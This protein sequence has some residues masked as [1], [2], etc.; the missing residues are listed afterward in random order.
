MSKDT[1][2]FEWSTKVCSNPCIDSAIFYQ[3]SV[4]QL[5]MSTPFIQ[6]LFAHWGCTQQNFSI[7]K[8]KNHN[9]HKSPQAI[10]AMEQAQNTDLM[11]AYILLVSTWHRMILA[12]RIRS[13]RFLPRISGAW[14]IILCPPPPPGHKIPHQIGMS[15]L[16]HCSSSC[17]PAPWPAPFAV[18]PSPT[19]AGVTSPVTTQNTRKR[20]TCHGPTG[21]LAI[22]GGS[23]GC[24]Y[25]TI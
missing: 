3:E 12:P 4:R 5:I 13:P 14:Y 21:K 16:L 1:T 23:N 20:S 6:D 2:V 11:Y 18:T 7:I 22:G 19:A 8:L 25:H 15:P 17:L 10:S 24:I 9:N